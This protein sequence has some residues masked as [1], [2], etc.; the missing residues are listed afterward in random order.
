[1]SKTKSAKQNRHKKLGFDKIA[2][3][4]LANNVA[5]YATKTR[6]IEAKDYYLGLGFSRQR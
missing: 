1:M 4:I 2:R 3:A 5:E 6:E